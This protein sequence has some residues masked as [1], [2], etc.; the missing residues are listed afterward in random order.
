VSLVVAVELF[1]TIA[2]LLPVAPSDPLG[3][4]RERREVRA[5]G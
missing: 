3:R 1:L 2:D 4:E 5:A